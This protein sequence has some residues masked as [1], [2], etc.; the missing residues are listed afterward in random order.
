MSNL[1]A[2]IEQLRDADQKLNESAPQPFPLPI[3]GLEAVVAGSLLA[4]DDGDWWVPGLRE[5][6][7]AVL[8]EAPIERIIDGLSGAKPYRIAPPTPSPALRALHAVGLALATPS[9]CTL[10]HL[11]VGSAADGAWFEALNT[12]ALT[13]ANLIFLVAV[14]PLEGGS[15]I[16]QQLASGPAAIAEGVGLTASV[17]DGNDVTA[18]HTAVRK[19]RKAGGPHV[20]EARLNPTEDVL[21]R[22]Q[23]QA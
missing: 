21:S 9:A 8:R 10:V 22:A 6:V 3:S 20:I 12:A 19:A 4:L 23:Q 7:G 17:I 14:H 15:P 2:A 1:A 16:P 5:R 18:V 11:G 13:K